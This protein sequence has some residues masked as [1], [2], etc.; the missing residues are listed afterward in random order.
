MENGT[1]ATSNNA[2]LN[3]HSGAFLSSF[4]ENVAMSD[5]GT[6]ILVSSSDGLIFKSSNY[7]AQFVNP[8]VPSSFAWSCVAVS[9]SGAIMYA[10]TS[11]FYVSTNYGESFTP[12]TLSQSCASIAIDASGS[13]MIS[14]D[15]S[16]KV[17]IS[18]YFGRY[19]NS[20]A[21][22]GSSVAVDASASIILVAESYG[23]VYASY[24]LGGSWSTL[25]SALASWSLLS[26]TRAT[27]QAFVIQPST[28]DETILFE[29]SCS[30]N[31]IS[32]RR[33]DALECWN[34]LSYS[35]SANSGAFQLSSLY[36]YAGSNGTTIFAVNANQVVMSSNG[37]Q[38][39]S[40]VSFPTFTLFSSKVYGSLN[41][42]VI[43]VVRS[44]FPV[45]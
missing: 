7:G 40:E 34:P 43:L 33:L 25:S 19:M 42:E 44:I 17:V 22:S 9:S 3:W 16:G 4:T 20:T 21:V 11:Q 36:A 24:D 6:H 23:Y 39:W 12:L 15:S 13:L 31:L 29:Y 2:G 38:S 18:H 32:N 1:F 5:T 30:Y 26:L 14:A 27:H 35:L 28:G 8:D 45:K 41:G 37:G 10:A